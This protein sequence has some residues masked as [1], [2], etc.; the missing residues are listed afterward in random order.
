[1]GSY[2]SKE[3]L[4]S[5]STHSPASQ[6]ENSAPALKLAGT[7][8]SAVQQLLALQ[9]ASPK[10]KPAQL[11]KA[12]QVVQLARWKLVAQDQWT[13]IDPD[14][15][16]QTNTT[17]SGTHPAGTVW[18]DTNGNTTPPTAFGGSQLASGSYGDWRKVVRPE[19]QVDHFPPNASYKGTPFESIPYAHRPAFPIRNREGHRPAQGE[20]YGYGGH[21]STTN[22]TF[23]QKG[24]TPDLNDMM[25]KGDFF[26]ALKKE[27][28]D[29]SNVAL[30][31][32]GSRAAFNELLKPGLQL[33][34]E[35]KLI[36]EQEYFHL[37]SML[38]EFKLYP[39]G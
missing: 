30:Y 10:T 16:G 20:E 4:A 17:P 15:Y 25:K 12:G 22:S 26:G 19:E 7:V 5:N 18:E 8:N 24:Y 34:F 37:L 36:T 32:Y 33:A 3:H 9:Q 31:Q 35:R 2:A 14:N 11:V 29:K 13:G 1:M 39:K 28:A 6:L 38:E 27:L 21:V 23:V